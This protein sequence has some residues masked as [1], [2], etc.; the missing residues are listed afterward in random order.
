M[1]PTEVEKL[2]ALLPMLRAD[3]EA[4]SLTSDEFTDCSNRFTRHTD[5]YDENVAISRITAV[6]AGPHTVVVRGVGVWF[7]LDKHDDESLW[8]EVFDTTYAASPTELAKPCLIV[9][10]LVVPE[11]LRRRGIGTAVLLAVET[12]AR[13]ENKDVVFKPVM[14]DDIHEFLQKRGYRPHI[15]FA[16]VKATK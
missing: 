6:M 4:F 15:G 10:G 5:A 7:L 13:V 9:W 3:V 1:E 12:R 14:E 11:R 2:Q 16:L 8:L